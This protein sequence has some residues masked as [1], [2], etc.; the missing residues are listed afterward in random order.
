MYLQTESCLYH[1]AVISSH[2]TGADMS[3][4]PQNKAPKYADSSISDKAFKNMII[5]FAVYAGL[6]C[7]GVAIAVNADKL[8]MG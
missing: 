2:E 7:L 4:E 5:W 6:F 1:N 8:N 3:Q